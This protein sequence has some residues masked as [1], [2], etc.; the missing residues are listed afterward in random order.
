M[1]ETLQWSRTGTA[2]VHHAFPSDAT[3]SHNISE[4]EDPNFLVLS[5]SQWS[6]H[7]AVVK[8]RGSPR[9]AFYQVLRTCFVRRRTDM[10]F[11][12]TQTLVRYCSTKTDF[13]FLHANH[14]L[15]T[16]ICVSVKSGDLCWRWKYGMSEWRH[17]SV[18][19]IQSP[20]DG[21]RFGPPCVRLLSM[22]WTDGFTLFG[23]IL[24]HSCVDPYRQQ[25]CSFWALLAFVE[26]QALH[27]GAHVIFYDSGKHGFDFVHS[28]KFLAHTS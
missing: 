8:V 25:S 2:R 21:F 22:S 20:K 4:E 10:L 9:H 6:D 15:I 3:S 14:R 28:S 12:R 23:T 11:K 19:C 1:R 17:F 13:R 7:V 5:H 24:M 18:R 27:I 26:Y 16:M